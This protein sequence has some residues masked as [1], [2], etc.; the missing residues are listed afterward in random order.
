MSGFV[1]PN[2]SHEV[3]LASIEQNIAAALFFF[4]LMVDGGG[5]GDVDC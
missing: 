5:A 4:F 1:S 2:S 3:V